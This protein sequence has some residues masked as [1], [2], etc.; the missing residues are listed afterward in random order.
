MLRRMLRWFLRLV[1]MIVIL[2]VIAL[3]SDYMSHRVQIGSVLVVKLSHCS[4]MLA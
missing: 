1:A 2:V 3:V 4:Q